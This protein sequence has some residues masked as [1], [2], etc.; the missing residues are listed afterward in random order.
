MINSFVLKGDLCY[1]AGPS[2]IKTIAAGYLVCEDGISKGG[3]EQLPDMYA[4]LPLIDC[5][6]KLIIP[7]LVDLHMHAPQFGYRALGMDLELLEWLNTYTF[8]E[9]AKYSDPKY[10]RAAYDWVVD[11]LKRG[12]NTRCV[13]FASAHSEATEI[14][15]DAMEK[16]GLVSYVGRVNMDRN[17]PD[18][19]RERD[20]K[21][22]FDQTSDWAQ[23]TAN[24]YVRTKPIL[25]PRFIPSCTDALMMDLAVY[26][27]ETGL[28]IQSHL[29]EN[30]NEI[31]W[32]QQL[33]PSST[34]YTDAYYQFGL[35]R[36]LPTIMAH[37]VWCDDD[38]VAHLK[39]SGTFVAH[40][41][42]SN[43]NIASGIAP[44]RHYLNAGLNMGL[45]SD[46]A[47]GAHTSIFRAMTDAI[48]VSKLRWRLVD[49]ADAP[50]T[51]AEAFYLATVGGGA[52]FGK[53]GSF[54][55][56]YEFDALVINDAGLRSPRRLSIEDRLARAAYLSDDRHI[57]R[58]YVRGL[59]VKERQALS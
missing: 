47:G 12:P 2:E 10:A 29:S 26:Q 32:V 18:G 13:L 9:E 24:K 34:S 21:W 41:P 8:P 20:A 42:Q 53:V 56:G 4:Q 22:A 17:A 35:M 11:D 55:E 38:E 58:K 28:P 7:G 48:Q 57:V 54:D 3:Y 27:R 39:Q 44:I 45:G 50:L 25:T 16:T 33:C 14:L 1:S 49:Q 52:F 46:V 19:L 43:T 37:C 23:R 5:G 59:E 30:K 40:C 31:A 6:G 36:G 51:M 15:M